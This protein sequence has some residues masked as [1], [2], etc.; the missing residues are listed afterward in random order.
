[1][2]VALAILVIVVFAIYL[3][4]VFQEQ[5]PKAVPRKPLKV[6]HGR[7]QTDTEFAEDYSFDFD[8]EEDGLEDDFLPEFYG[9]DRLVLM[10]KDPEWL[11]AYWEITANTKKLFEEQT[12]EKAWFASQPVLRIYNLTEGNYFDIKINDEA[13]NWYIWI[14]KPNTKYRAEIG[15]IYEGKYYKLIQSNQLISPAFGFSEIIDPQWLPSKEIWR[16]LGSEYE[17]AYGSN[18][19]T[20]NE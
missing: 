5:Q 3:F 10:A 7:E 12:R 17:F 9:E 15:R 13:D 1:M 11:Y 18:H 20:K 6:S 4:Y 19:L 2:I 14:K 16:T 8:Q